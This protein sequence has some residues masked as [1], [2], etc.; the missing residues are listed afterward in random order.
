MTCV[1]CGKTALYI[2]PSG[3]R[4]REHRDVLMPADLEASQRHD[5]KSASIEEG[6]KEA[7]TRWYE[8]VTARHRSGSR[9]RRHS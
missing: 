9:G 1:V 5:R 7:E 2:Q 6:K 3:G 4:C 8:N